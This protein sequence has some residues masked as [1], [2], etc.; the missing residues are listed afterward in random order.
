M[1]KNIKTIFL[2]GILCLIVFLGKSFSVVYASSDTT[3]MVTATTSETIKQGNSGTCY[4]Y[5]ESLEE[6]SSLNVTVHYDSSK[7][8]LNNHYNSVSCTLYDS[9]VSD[10][11]IQ[12]SYILMAMEK[13]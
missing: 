6:L 3:N 2:F 5:I 9:S 10:S 11:Y 8:K 1:R 7:I 13:I 4:V 12:Y